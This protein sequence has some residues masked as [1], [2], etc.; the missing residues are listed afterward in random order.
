MPDGREPRL[1]QFPGVVGCGIIF[2]FGTAHTRRYSNI[3][4]NTSFLLIAHEITASCLGNYVMG[5]E[6]H[7]I[8][9]AIFGLSRAGAHFYHMPGGGGRS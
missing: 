1:S 2:F 6:L 7:S 5:M 3:S 8:W 9:M 4:D